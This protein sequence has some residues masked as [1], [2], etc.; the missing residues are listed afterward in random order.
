MQKALERMNVKLHDV[1]SSLIGVNLD[2][3]A[4]VPDVRGKGSHGGYAGPAVKPIALNM[5][6][7]VAA[8]PEARAIGRKLFP[9]QR[10]LSA[11]D[12]NQG[13]E[14]WIRMMWSW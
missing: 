7:Q 14:R 11:A 10:R 8:D 3:W 6:S 1:I 12:R 4:P 9:F 13:G 2:S 5:V